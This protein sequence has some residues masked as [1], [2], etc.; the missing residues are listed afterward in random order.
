MNKATIAFRLM[1]Y[2]G[3]CALLMLLV[4]VGRPA[5]P[6]V[7]GVVLLTVVMCSVFVSDKPQASKDSE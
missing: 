5:L 3:G 7:P 2:I 1:G 6:F 4:N